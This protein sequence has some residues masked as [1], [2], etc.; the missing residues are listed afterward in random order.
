MA[1]TTKRNAGKDVNPVHAPAPIKKKKS[2]LKNWLA[3]IVV[4][5]IIGMLVLAYVAG[6]NFTTM[7]VTHITNSFV[8]VNGDGKPDFILNADVILNTGQVSFPTSQP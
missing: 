6:R 5:V 4:L 3:V 7:P 2:K 8:D 1:I